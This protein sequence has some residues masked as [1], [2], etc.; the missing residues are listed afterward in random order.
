MFHG[1]L[2]NRRKQALPS[3]K[4]ELFPTVKQTTYNQNAFLDPTTT[5][6]TPLTRENL[7]SVNR[8]DP[9][10]PRRQLD[11]TSPHEGLRQKR[12]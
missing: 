7:D 1:E 10:E 5:K 9:K 3:E 8:F 2:E 6:K 12:E 11:A 4:P